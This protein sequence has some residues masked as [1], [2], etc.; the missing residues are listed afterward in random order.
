MK[1][2]FGLLAVMWL[3][4]PAM[5]QAE[6]RQATSRNFTVYSEGGEQELRGATAKLEKLHLILRAMQNVT[7]PPSPLKLRV[8][9]MDNADGVAATMAVPFGGVQGYYDAGQRGPFLIGTRSAGGSETGL[10]PVVVLQHEYSHGFMFEYFPAT[11]PTWYVEGFAEFWGTLRILDNDVVEVG[12]PAGHR[13]ASFTDNRW[14]PLRKI[15][16]ARSYADVSD[17]DLIYAEGWLLLRY[18]FENKERSGQLQSYLTAINKGV[19]YEKAMDDAFG[20]GAKALDEELIRY[21][22]SPRFSVLRVPF[23]PID[24]GPIEIRTLTPAE[25][26]LMGS[27]IRATRGLLARETP[28]FVHDV[29]SAAARYPDD[30]AALLMLA[31]AERLAGNPAGAG[32]AADRLL[33]LQPDNPRGLVHKGMAALEGLKA[34]GT[35]AEAAWTEAR[36]PLVRAVQLAPNDPVVLEAYYDSFVVQGV[37][38]PPGAQNALFR[39]LNLVPADDNLRYRVAADFERRDMIEDAATVIRPA[40]LAMRPENEKQKKARER[41]EE[42]YRL[43][44]QSLHETPAEMLKRLES[45][46]AARPAAPAPAGG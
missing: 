44:G 36:R 7:R 16:G 42:K 14:L 8:F 9:L 11:Y 3:L 20:P 34:S 21:A 37:L 24:V 40:A 4:V 17:V 45:K 1:R 31:E 28:D 25:A 46:L 41:D 19:S 38:P 30:P 12:Q 43:A 29:R 27:E 32:A 6:W 15:L 10:D 13:F 39:A 18:L 5:A 26:A 35:A 33:R 22:G 23:R 2:L